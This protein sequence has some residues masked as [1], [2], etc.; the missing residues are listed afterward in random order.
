MRAPRASSTGVSTGLCA[1]SADDEHEQ[2]VEPEAID[3]LPGQD[4][5]ADVRR[6]ERA[7][8]EPGRHASSNSTT[9][10][11]LIPAARSSSSVASP[12]TR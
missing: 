6:V 9:A 1:G 8:E 5:M 2:P 11:G 10:S 4:D 12:R 3:R 7:A